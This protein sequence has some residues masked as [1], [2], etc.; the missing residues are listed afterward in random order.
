MVGGERGSCGRDEKYIKAFT[1]E[2]CMKD[3][4]WKI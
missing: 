2:I 4:T 1:G 3:I